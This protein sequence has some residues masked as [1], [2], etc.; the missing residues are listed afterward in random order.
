MTSFFDTVTLDRFAA[1]ESYVISDLLE[2]S[3]KGANCLNNPLCSPV[4]H[5]EL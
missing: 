1:F 5:N 4:S 2:S 3:K